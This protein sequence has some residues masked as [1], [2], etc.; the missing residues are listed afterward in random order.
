MNLSGPLSGNFIGPEVAFLEAPVD[1][2]ATY[3]ARKNS[4]PLPDS[5]AGTSFESFALCDRTV[6]LPFDSKD[7]AIRSKF[8]FEVVVVSKESNQETIFMHYHIIYKKRAPWICIILHPT[9]PRPQGF[10]LKKWVGRPTHLREKPWGR[11]C[12]LLPPHSEN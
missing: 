10:S 12:I 4:G 6:L 8:N 2:P 5:R 3:W 9:Q 7:S 11:G 1:F